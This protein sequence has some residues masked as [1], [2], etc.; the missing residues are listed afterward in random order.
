MPHAHKD[1]SQPMLMLNGELH[2][3]ER[4]PATGTA[5]IGVYNLHHAR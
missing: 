3:M 5:D 2:P 4:Q 1:E